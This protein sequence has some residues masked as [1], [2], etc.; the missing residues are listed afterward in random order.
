MIYQKTFLYN[1]LYQLTLTTSVTMPLQ[2]INK[3]KIAQHFSVFYISTIEYN[4]LKNN[5]ESNCPTPESSNRFQIPDTSLMII[6][7]SE[8]SP[9]NQ[10]TYPQ[11]P[12]SLLLYL[13][14]VSCEYGQHCLISCGMFKQLHGPPA[15]S[16][17]I[18]FSLCRITF[19][20]S[21]D[22]NSTATPTFRLSFES[23]PGTPDTSPVYSLLSKRRYCLF[24]QVFHTLS[25]NFA[26]EGHKGIKIIWFEQI[27]RMF[28]IYFIDIQSV[29]INSPIRLNQDMAFTV[30]PK[31]IY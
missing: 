2:L 19:T 21:K 20:E 10:R 31:W 6:W 23:S 5:I 3:A 15:S 13:R 16:F 22:L 4:P 24:G 18:C 30:I 28:L 11:H 25:L 1:S 8:N 7:S 9:W 29:T 27:Y 12:T 17:R 26:I 14:T